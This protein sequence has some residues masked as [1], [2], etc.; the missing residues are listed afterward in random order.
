MIFYRDRL[1]PE[2]SPVTLNRLLAIGTSEEQ[3]QFRTALEGALETRT[4]ALAP[5]HLGLNLD[6][7]APFNRFAAAAG[8]ATLGWNR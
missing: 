5:Q 2:D 8:L 4:H 1:L 7:N 6:P 3:K